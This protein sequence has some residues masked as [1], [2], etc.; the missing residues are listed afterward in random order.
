MII[1]NNRNELEASIIGDHVLIEVD[2]DWEA[3]TG[4]AQISITKEAAVVLRDFLNG[5]IEHSTSK[6][7]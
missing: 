1:K 2:S 7:E 4:Y 5:F 3:P 6:Q